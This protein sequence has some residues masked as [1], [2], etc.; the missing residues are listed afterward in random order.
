MA[1]LSGLLN[2]STSVAA[3]RDRLMEVLCRC[4]IRSSK[5]SFRMLPSLKRSVVWLDFESKHAQSFN[6]LVEVIQRNIL[7]ADW[8]EA[9]H[10]ES[11]LNPKN[12]SW[13][14]EMAK[15]LRLSCCIAGNTNLQVRVFGLLMIG[16]S[17]SQSH[18]SRS[19]DC[20]F[21]A[22]Q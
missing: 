16:T 19:I 11:L 13:G 15:N 1:S 7:L 10:H 8:G 20:V 12:S 14:R 3:G 2:W 4:F 22:G 17:G 21:I 6:E 18:M 5:D 9:G